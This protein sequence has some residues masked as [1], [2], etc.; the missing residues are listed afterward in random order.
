MID[1]GPLLDAFTSARPG[2]VSVSDWSLYLYHSRRFGLGV[3]DREIGN[4]HAPLSLSEGGGARYRL[5]W[6]DGSVSR[7]H[8]ERCQIAG[9]PLETLNYARAAAYE[10]PDAA[11]VRA[12]APMPDVELFDEDAA[13]AAGGDTRQI[14]ERLAAVRR[15][16]DD[17]GI[18]TWS[19]SFAA[20][21]G[22]SRVITSAGLDVDDRS[23]TVGWHV[24]VNGEIGEGFG[25]RRAESAS[26]FETRLE[27]LME[28][29]ARLRQ[30][31]SDIAGGV[32]PVVLHPDVVE[33]YVI[34]TLLDNL[35]G[36]TVANGEGHFRREQFGA[37]DA[38]LRDDL[39][40]RLDPLESFKRGSYR[41]TSEGVPAARCNYIERGRLVQPLLDLKYAR[42]LA[43]EPTPL[44]LSA[45]TLQLEGPER[46]TLDQALEAAG[47]GVLVLSVLGVHTQ[48]SSSGDFSLSAPQALG[49]RSGRYAG[50]Q[51]GTISGNLFTLLNDP[52]LRLVTFEG[53]HTPGLL[54]PVRFDPQ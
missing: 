42:R 23:T 15:C 31:G 44:P 22:W 40:L 46:L 14:A 47:N 38:V 36:A 19:G 12:A 27:R 43:R 21:E 29:A 35:G 4:P 7:G 52:S 34:D 9:D 13:A 33:S 28:T 50:R 45:D 1:V 10:D 26:E 39:T 53:E 24:S 41:F 30:S 6:S 32:I 5:I 2:G 17:P 51:R 49:I 18:N 37:A 11:W 8:L 54:L 16:M 25:A 3:K 48:D 20:S